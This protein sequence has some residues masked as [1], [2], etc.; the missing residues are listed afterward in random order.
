MQ[1][2]LNDSRVVEDHQTSL[3]QQR[4]QVAEHRLADL[5]AFI[6]KQLAA[7][8]LLQRELRNAL[9]GQRIVVVVYLNVFCI[10][11]RLQKYKDFT[12]YEKTLNL[13]L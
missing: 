12:K 7:V 10:H 8:A 2:S 9:I 13:N 6:D 3:W 5:S 1:S 11:K 4:R